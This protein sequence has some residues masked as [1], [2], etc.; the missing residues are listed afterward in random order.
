LGELPG[1]SAPLGPNAGWAERWTEAA[2]AV[3][4][5]CCWLAAPW[6]ALLGAGEELEAYV[7]WSE[8]GRLLDWLTTGLP[9]A[10][11]D[12]RC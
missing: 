7:W 3:E 1:P 9:P 8:L 11:V 12:G 10:R 2:D 5:L 4:A 6:P